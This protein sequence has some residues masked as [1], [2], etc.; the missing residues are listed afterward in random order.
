MSDKTD[1]ESLE[2]S[3]KYIP[4]KGKKAEWYT[5]HKTFLVW[6]M[7]RGYHGIL[8]ELEAIPTDETAK[9]LATL[10]DMTSNK[11][12]QYNN[13]NMHTRAHADLLQCCTQ[14]IVSFRIVDM[15][16]DKDLVNGNTALA[17]K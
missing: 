8:V 10:T 7:I 17:W 4:W 3:V 12:K 6:E 16:K 15:A 11:K 2:N 13:Y 5:W 9:K 1:Y 14:D